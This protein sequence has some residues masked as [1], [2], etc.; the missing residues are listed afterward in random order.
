[1]SKKLKPGQSLSEALNP[2][3][4]AKGKPLPAPGVRWPARL[5]FGPYP[6]NSPKK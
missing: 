4:A 6:P 2:E 5:P 3:L 1:M